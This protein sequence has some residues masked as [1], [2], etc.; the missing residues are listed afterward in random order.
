MEGVIL[1]RLPKMKCIMIINW[2][3]SANTFTSMEDLATIAKQL[4]L[5]HGATRYHMCHLPLHHLLDG[6]MLAITG[7]SF[8]KMRLKALVKDGN[9]NYLPIN[10]LQMDLIPRLKILFIYLVVLK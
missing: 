2:P 7:N 9:F 3:C 4:V 8:R 1:R 5:I 10:V 6:L